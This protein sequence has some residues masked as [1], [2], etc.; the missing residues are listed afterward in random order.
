MSPANLTPCEDEFSR[1]LAACDEAL[2][3][4]EA[5]PTPPQLAAPPELTPR[6]DRARA[7]LLWLE[8]ARRRSALALASADT[9]APSDCVTE[10][11]PL[12][13]K[14][15]GRFE[16]RREL[17]RG[18]GGIVFLAFDPVLR[19]EVA[20]KVPRPE[21]I[22]TPE[23]RRRFLRE[24]RAAAGLE[25]PHLVTVHEVGE[26]GPLC[27]LVS[28][29]CRGPSLSAW[30]K[31]QREAVPPRDA[32]A[33]VATLADAVHF[34]HGRGIIH[35]DIKPSNILLASG[36]VVSSDAQR[37]VQGISGGGVC[38]ESAL[39]REDGQRP[40]ATP[41][42]HH[43]PLTTDHSPL[44]TYQPKLSDFGLA[45]PAE[46]DDV[47]TRT[48]AVLGTPAYMAPE[49]ADGG[50]NVGPA[51]DV[52]AMGVLLYELLTGRPPFKA[53]TAIE[54]LRQVMHEEPVPPGRLRAG[55]SR[56]LESVCL[57]CLEKKP[58][59]RYASAAALAED[60]RRFLNGQA[61][62][63]RPLSAWQHGWKGLR[64]RPRLALAASAGLLAVVALTGV[65]RYVASIQ[66]SAAALSADVDTARQQRDRVE[67]EANTARQRLY[68]RE[69][70]LLAESANEGGL[71]AAQLA[72]TGTEELHGFEWYYLRCR[73]DTDQAGTEWF[74]GRGHTRPVVRV[75]FSPDGRLCASAGDDGRI[76][77][78]DLAT[79]SRRWFA[80]HKQ[81]A[82]AV[83]FSP[84][85]KSLASSS[86]Q[87]SRST[88]L[89]LWDVATGTEQAAVT[90]P[91]R[92]MT[93]G[94][95]F[96][97][98]GQTL[99][100]CGGALHDDA[101]QVVLWDLRSGR[102]RE[103]ASPEAGCYPALAFSPDGHALA[104]SCGHGGGPYP[105]P[106]WGAI[107]LF[108]MASG[109]RTAR[110][111]GHAVVVQWVTFTPDGKTLI[112]GDV[113]STVKVWDMAT[114]QER[115]N[116][117]A[118]TH[119]ALSPDGNTLAAVRVGRDLNLWDVATGR[120]IARVGSVPS[121]V[122]CMRFGP[123]GT[124]LAV[125]CDDH[126]VRLFDTRN[127]HDLPGHR[128]AEAWAVAFA[129][130][131]KT[132]ATAGDDHTIRLWSV[133][134]FQQRSVLR[135]HT[136]L[137]ASV[138]FSPDG[139]TLASGSFDHTVQLWD[140][141][142]GRPK[143]VHHGHTQD[144]RVVAFSP[145]GRLLA[146]A[147]R[148]VKQTVGELRIWD[149][150]TGKERAALAANGNCLA[151]SPD[152]RL[153]A[154]QGTRDSAELL[155]VSTLMP[156]RI[157]LSSTGVT[158]VTFAPNGKTLATAD[159]NGL[160]RLWDVKTGSERKGPRAWAGGE[161]H[162]LAFSPDGKTLASAGM[163][164]TIRL[165]QAASRLE[166]FRFRNLPDYAHALAFSPNSAILA[167]A[168]HDGT[169]RVYVGDHKR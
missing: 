13:V 16:V 158:C 149:L 4:G 73:S 22:L 40:Q 49:Q 70:A 94:L 150:A 93:N 37:F 85:G 38:N 20:V 98:D 76:I 108:D 147:A 59:R 36:E 39:T 15:L 138:A 157:L 77:V 159:T 35:R 109:K 120:R 162:A 110:L 156:A 42:T 83:V 161:V 92:Q 101:S 112:S 141:A 136:A 41:T 116:L 11:K 102:W 114:G 74:V 140:V 6:L 139:R 152:G 2:A 127:I 134:G 72:A 51:T 3:A 117:R 55:L 130:D 45:R 7:C 31:Q 82:T 103:L 75:A 71:T 137:V 68:P 126:T 14:V 29:Y 1:L 119:L 43:S 44:T 96:A 107:Q 67:A 33:L 148:S 66:D 46:R 61:T 144:I 26:D 124:Q 78:W 89:K 27:Y 52:H 34:M 135:G 90:V 17:G 118:G 151:F 163:D 54:V 28:T 88:E 115:L 53:G 129:P 23:L 57:K 80:G 56:D 32:A 86:K 87:S 10:V 58:E 128:P 47:H 133:P 113:E 5:A 62:Q 60:L 69:I 100:A 97:P 131:G 19:R 99:A 64:R 25:H 106:G 123:S 160:V 111:T 104:V 167:V 30:L 105:G 21:A 168:C 81:V 8:R 84:D 169:V 125:A 79:H 50:E 142:T 146:T 65:G 91:R 122:H 63:A 121:Q 18:G 145:D 165:W 143:T 154:F 24:A 166:L 48:G 153:L 132:L 95:A 9:P 164:R 155:D 12:P